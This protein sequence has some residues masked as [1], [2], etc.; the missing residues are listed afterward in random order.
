MCMG[1]DVPT[2]DTNDRQ[3]Y[4]LRLHTGALRERVRH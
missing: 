1:K 4:A 2:S 3:C